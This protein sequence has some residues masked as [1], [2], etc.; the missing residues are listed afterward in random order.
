MNIFQIPSLDKTSN[1]FTIGVIDCSGSMES[2]WMWLAEHW[3]RFI[4]TDRSSIIT[5]DL[6]AKIPSDNRLKPEIYSHGG[7]GTNITAGFV[8]LDQEI[9]KMPAK[10]KITVIFISDG[11]DNN[12]AT[13]PARMSEL[14]G[15]DGTKRIN[16]ICIGVG[17][18]F[19]TFISMKLREKYHNGDETLPAIF[20]IEHVSEKAYT[21]KFEAIKPFLTVGQTRVVVP[22]VCVFPWREYTDK[23]FERTWIMTDAEVIQ[24]DGEK[25]DMKPFHLNLRGINE[26]FRSWNQ[27]INL[28]SMNQGEKVDLRAKKTLALMDQILEELKEVKGID[29]FAKPKDLK[30]NTI[31]DRF[32][33]IVNKRNFERTVWFYD[34]VKK[35][36]AGNTAGGLSDFEAAKRIGLGTIVGKYAQKAFALKN[37]S[38]AEFEVIKDEFKELLRTHKVV[39]SETCKQPLR[40]V[41]MDQSLDKA[42]DLVKNQLELFETFPLH[43]HPA[44][45]IRNDQGQI[46]A[47][48]VDLRYLGTDQ[49]L[50]LLDITSEQGGSINVTT[51]DGKQE[52]VNAVVPLFGKESADLAP[53]IN[54]R[55]YKLLMSWNLI[56]DPDTLLEDSFSCMLTAAFGNAIKA[57]KPDVE[58]LDKICFN[59]EL[60][61]PSLPVGDLYSNTPTDLASLTK[62]LDL[63]KKARTAPLS[64]ALLNA[65][66]NFKT[67]KV[68][69]DQL[70]TLL[71]WATVSV[72]KSQ[73]SNNIGKLKA[74][75]ELV[76]IKKEADESPELKIANIIKS[77]L[78]KVRSL[79][80]LA[81]KLGAAI[82][83]F[84]L[85]ADVEITFLPN[86]L[87]KLLETDEQFPLIK[88]FRSLTGVPEPSAADAEALVFAAYDSKGE[89]VSLDSLADT[90]TIKTDVTTAI[91]NDFKKQ[92]EAVDAHKKKGKK[93]KAVAPTNSCPKKNEMNNNSLFKLL[94]PKLELEFQNLFKNVHKEVI[95]LSISEYQAVCKSNGNNFKSVKFNEATLLPV[96]TCAAQNCYYFMRNMP[97]LDSHLNVWGVKLPQGFHLVVKENRAKSTKEI[98]DIFANSHFTNVEGKAVPFD[99][100]KFDKTEEEVLAYI[101][102]L[103]AAYTKLVPN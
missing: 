100:V 16:F 3:N 46:D 17:P 43:G 42:L 26:L 75:F 28:E 91:K 37:I 86:K 53:F 8:M 73:L 31:F 5:F 20:L 50:E 81:R 62:E 69:A 63:D 49:V 64:K 84:T 21:I 92:S 55:L 12:I 52:T 33:I 61:K 25:I 1:D 87:E 79:G 66:L 6:T 56:R 35:I 80:D 27:M 48:R 78:P 24:V 51:A 39:A 29:V 30:F 103:K 101:D 60:V 88:A 95:P 94:Y 57:A 67:G 71:N 85:N 15:N 13:L 10:S 93:G 44:K 68:T 36:A 82:T 70:K 14:D 77:Q 34:D 96:R 89:D 102:K 4:P 2:N 38:P 19:P 23:V 9:A 7:G 18:G 76:I 45:I 59:L 74:L 98:Y 97:R 72:L 83:E 32:Q 40:K 22:P 11:E 58:L 65:Y 47:Q 41:L 90:S 99:P 54:S